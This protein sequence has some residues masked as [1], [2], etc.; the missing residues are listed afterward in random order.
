MVLEAESDRLRQQIAVL[1][2]R[3]DKKVYDLLRDEVELLKI[4][5][6]LKRATLDM[7]RLLWRRLNKF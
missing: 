6:M 5:L 1:L 2:Q 7:G 4:Y 3:G